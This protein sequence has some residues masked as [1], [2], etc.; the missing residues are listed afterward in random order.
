MKLRPLLATTAL[1]ATMTLLS[2]ASTFAESDISKPAI[3]KPAAAPGSKDAP[4][5]DQIKTDQTKTDQK[6]ADPKEERLPLNDLR[7]FTEVFH[8][9]REAY[10]EEV[11]DRTLLENA[12]KGML[13]GLDP[14]SAYLDEHSFSDLRV[15]TTG[16]FGGVGL[17]VGAEDGLVKVI[18]AIDDTPAQKA[19]IEAGDLI[20]KLDN[21]PIK[22]MNLTDA[23]K[24]MRGEKGSKVTLTILREGV[25]QPFD[26]TLT[27]EVVHVTSVRSKILEP[28][29]GYIRIAQFQSNTGEDF[30][31]AIDKLKRSNNGELKGIVMDLRN[32][33]GGVL[34]ASVEVV[35]ALVDSGLIVYTKGR[36]PNAETSFRA[37]PGDIIKGAPA[38]VLINGGSASA[39][40][41]VAGAL[42]D[43]KRA[44]IVGTQSFGKGSVQTVLPLPENRAIKLT[45][46]LYFTPNGRSI[47]AEGIV[48]DITVERAKLTKVKD[49]G[50]IKEADLSHHL[51]N[52]ND[53]SKKKS[54]ENVE[55]L[56]EQDNQLYEALNL[57][58]GIHLLTES[59]AIKTPK[60]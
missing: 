9:I 2:P 57:L 19:G 59:G 32:N 37:S 28:G 56:Q 45:T 46:A 29:Y 4:H 7:V 35:D 50:G 53:A 55:D 40:E 44:L 17:E 27:R 30:R 36:L 5:P 22:G 1:F 13:A 51:D 8:Q 18:T 10:V 47:Q 6:K 20:I 23:V 26:I 54:K 11:D 38:V 34:Q 3:Q 31:K 24:M 49:I 60:T 25:N 21:Q 42:Q 16:E 12:I 33:P 41:I 48:P 52:A 39:S 58:K 15:S 43:H 14:H